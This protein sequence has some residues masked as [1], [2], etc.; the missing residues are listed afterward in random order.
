MR[1][2][3]CLTDDSAKRDPTGSGLLDGLRFVAKDLISLKGHISSFGHA[4]WRETHEA[5]IQDSSVI[6]ALLAE[7]AE[8]IGT[9]KMDQL[10]YS[11]IGNIG[12]GE[13][14][15]NTRYPERYCGGSSSGSAS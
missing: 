7:G 1:Q 13:A 8:L 9:A 15:A 14:P 3:H 10:A 4:Q 6:T 5:A 12:E 2:L 11:I